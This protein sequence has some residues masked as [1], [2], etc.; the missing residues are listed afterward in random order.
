[1]QRLAELVTASQHAIEHLLDARTIE[2]L[3]LG[4]KLRAFVATRRIDETFAIRRDLQHREISQ[5]AHDR[6]RE[7]DFIDASFDRRFD[8]RQ[9]RPCIARGERLHERARQRAIRD[10]E[11][12]GD[13]LLG[14]LGVT[15]VRDDLIG[16]RER[17]AHAAPRL[18]YEQTDRSGIDAELLFLEDR[19]EVLREARGRDELEIVPLAA[20]QDRVRQLV[21]LG[22]RE[23][24]GDVRRRLL[25]GLQQCVERLGREHV[26]F[27]DDVDLL[28]EHRGLVTH[29]FGEL[30]NRIDA[31]VG[32]AVHL[33]IIGRAPVLDTHARFARA[34]RRAIGRDQAVECL[35]DDTSHRGLAAAARAA[36]QEGVVHA[37]AD[38]RV[39]ERSCDVVLT[40]D[41]GKCRRAVF[42]GEYEIGHVVTKQARCG[43]YP[44][45]LSLQRQGLADLLRGIDDLVA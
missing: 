41:F 14:D 7:L 11:D 30:A 6:A 21:R 9:R 13:V 24:E 27:V 33:L 43:L 8:C 20:R 1:M 5:I 29:R 19:G 35:A 45:T 39:R 42:T 37:A 25:E 26:D 4:R 34:A 31:A 38:E 36:E 16:Q 2:L 40:D 22:R 44:V 28:L 18:A 3:G 32:C 15:D 23:H 10:A 17:I 12:F